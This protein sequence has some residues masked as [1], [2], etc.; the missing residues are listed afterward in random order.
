MRFTSASGTQNQIHCTWPGRS[1][2]GFSGSIGVFIQFLQRGPFQHRDSLFLSQDVRDL[3]KDTL[4]ACKMHATGAVSG[5]YH[6]IKLQ[7]V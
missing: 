6:L 1:S 2:T 3:M 4:D 7:T 5:R